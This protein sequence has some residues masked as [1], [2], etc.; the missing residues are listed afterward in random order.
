MDEK[1]KHSES[2]A[3]ENL[4]NKN[5]QENGLRGKTNSF[6]GTGSAGASRESSRDGNDAGGGGRAKDFIRPRANSTSTNINLLRESDRE[7]IRAVDQSTQHQLLRRIPS[8]LHRYAAT[9]RDQD[10]NTMSKTTKSLASAVANARAEL[11]EL[12]A[13]AHAGQLSSGDVAM[14]EMLIRESE[15]LLTE[16]KPVSGLLA[17]EQRMRRQFVHQVRSA[18]SSELNELTSLL[19]AKQ[20]E[21][22]RLREQRRELI[23]QYL[24]WR[25]TQRADAAMAAETFEAHIASSLGTNDVG[26]QCSVPREAI[27]VQL[28]K[29][30]RLMQEIPNLQRH[31]AEVR[32]LVVELSSADHKSAEALR[33]QACSDEIASPNKYYYGSNRR[34]SDKN[35]SYNSSRNH[36]R[37]NMMSG[38]L[39]LGASSTSL[40]HDVM[41]HEAMLV[42]PCGDTICARCAR[43][44]MLDYKDQPFKKCPAC[45]MI[46]LTE[47]FSMTP[48]LVVRDICA[49]WSFKMSGFSDVAAASD[50]LQHRLQA[51]KREEV[52]RVF[53]A[54]QQAV[55]LGDE[56]EL[57]RFDE[58]E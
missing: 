51:F 27:P 4:I 35:R 12:I 8:A 45:K 28:V 41:L 58:D 22:V 30:V 40:R 9:E 19:A 32:K 16:M 13:A 44:A 15:G 21:A 6:I 50:A 57:A 29:T 47:S 14:V 39:F 56:E 38:S 31:V 48:N 55:K 42:W 5:S 34:Q 46:S 53:E 33:C 37:N 10:L 1:E 7:R 11:E 17:G 20:R 18:A 23:R 36:S 24:M 49:K 2:P 26:T 54:V 3:K 25:Q 43:Q 52:M